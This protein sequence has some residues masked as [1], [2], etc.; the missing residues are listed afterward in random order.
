MRSEQGLRNVILYYIDGTVVLI[1]L[2]AEVVPDGCK[3]VWLRQVTQPV[4]FHRIL[5]FNIL[6]CY[7]ADGFRVY[8]IVIRPNMFL[9]TGSI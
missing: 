3:V 9:P 8:L 1:D 7:S 5:R 2:Y 4:V 6:Q